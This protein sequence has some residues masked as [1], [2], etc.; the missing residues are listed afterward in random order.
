MATASEA[1][2]LI[3]TIDHVALAVHDLD[4]A[5]ELYERAFGVSFR[6]RE[7]NDEQGY[8]VAAFYMD[9]LHVEL[10][11]PLRA[12]SVISGFLAKKG[13]GVHHIAFR[14]DD[15]DRALE[16]LRTRGIRVV[17]ETPRRGTADSRIAF[18]HPKAMLGTLIELVEPADDAESSR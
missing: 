6:W 4:A 10:L 7:R 8:E 5:V 1:L 2:S 9:G 13:A 3:D 17:D 12:D 14:V 11:A 15:I 18:V 16:Q